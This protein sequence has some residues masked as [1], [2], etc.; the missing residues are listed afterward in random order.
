MISLILD[1]SLQY[2]EGG[3]WFSP[4]ERFPEYRFENIAAKPNPIYRAVRDCYVQAGLDAEHLGTPQWNPLG[5]WI[6]QGDRV[7]VLCNFANERRP[8]EAWMDYRARCTHGSVIRAVIDYILIA[9]NG[10]GNVTFGNAPTQFCH[11]KQ[12]LKDNQADEVEQF[13]EQKGIPVHSKDLRLY[14]T[15]ATQLGAIRS[16]ERRDESMGIHVDLGR[17]SLLAELE[18]D[19]PQRYRVMNYDPDRTMQFHSTGRHEYVINRQILESDVI[20]SIPKLKTHEKVGISCALKGFVGTV[21]HKDSLPHH[22]YGSPQMAGDE[23][24][25]STKGVVKFST[26]YHESV[27]HTVPDSA[28]GSM[29]RASFRVLKRVIRPLAPVIEGAWWGNDT[30]WRMVLDLVRI[31]AYCSAEG[32]MQSIPVRKQL[33]LIDGIFGGEGE[34]PAYPTAVHCGVLQFGDNLPAVDALNALLMGFD[35]DKI[36]LVHRSLL[37]NKYPLLARPV[38]EET[39]IF[40][41]RAASMDEF[42]QESIFHFLPSEGWKERLASE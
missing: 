24:P 6:N 5:K 31:A 9:L 18:G 7:F 2:P 34:G 21:G 10:T 22:R 19:A 13:Y 38:E 41:G 35:P 15:D 14:V 40:N 29:L 4:D 17:D 8:D 39:I 1:Q 32:K 42:R 37:L 30:A 26:A 27:Q 25:D 11:W 3:E 28:G 20:F 12:V 36:P 33:A 23:Y 16:V